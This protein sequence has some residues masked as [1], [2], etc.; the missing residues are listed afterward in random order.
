MWM[1]VLVGELVGRA[2]AFLPVPAFLDG[3]WSRNHRVGL[4]LI[5][6]S[7]VLAI[8]VA[9]CG[10]SMVALRLG[11]RQNFLPPW[12]L[13]AGWVELSEWV[14]VPLLWLGLILGLFGL[15]VCWRAIHAGWRP[16]NRKLFALGAALS[17]GTSLVP[18]MTSADVLMYA[19]YGRLQV[20][21]LDPYSITPAEIFRQEFDPVLV[22]TE[23]PWQD[24]PSV[25]G[26]LASMSQWLAAWLGNGNMHDTV[27]WLQMWALLPFL[28]IGAIAVK[29]AHDDKVTQTRA[30]LFTVLNPLM[31]WSVLSGAHNEALTLVFAIVGLWFIRRSPFV[32]GIAIGLAGS[33]K[34]SLVFY[35]IAMMWGYRRDWRKLLQ[36]VI[37]ALIPLGLAYG[38]WVPRA[39]TAA[40]RNTGYISSGS[41]APPVQ[42]GLS[43]LIGH[44]ASWAVTVLIGWVL[45]V[46]I[47]WMLSRVLPWRLVPGNPDDDEP[48]LDPL[49]ITVRTAT[50]LT[51]A[52]LVSSPYT[53]SWYDLIA[54]VPL[55]LMTAS[56]LDLLMMGRGFWLAAAY[57]TGRAVEFS[58]A[59]RTVSS[60]VRD[61]A[62]TGFQILV[63]VAIVH[64]WWSWGHQLPRWLSRILP[65]KLRTPV[66]IE[67]R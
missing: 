28:V 63:L 51:T 35:G 5:I 26:P 17:I 40:S 3:P 47:G 53:L 56:R 31:I 55:G 22:W 23:R 37:G 52:W 60:I 15:W 45:M 19:A 58:P 36:L 11:P 8:G 33:V 65:A 62:C 9:A 12:Y 27:F 16:H 29:L 24:T 42:G 46:A 2:P 7:S 54:W 25:Y 30:V 13:P 10:P 57:V 32:A 64:W 4:G 49:T 67:P 59:M 61:W 6:A 43:F 34:V 21:G 38:V 18:P 41:W 39:L 14:A 50:I 44:D 66:G 20:L 48:R 1:E